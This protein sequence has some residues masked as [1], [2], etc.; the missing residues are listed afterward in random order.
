VTGRPGTLAAL[1]V[2]LRPVHWLKNVPV[3]A[4]LL[5]GGRLGDRGA[6]LAT[7]GAFLAFCGVAS[8]GYA[9]NDVADRAA[10]AAHPTRRLRP[11]AAGAVSP[12]AALALAAVLGLSSL[13]A[14]F[15]WLPPAAAFGLLAYAFLTLSYTAFAKRVTAL[16]APVLAAGFVLR[17]LVGAFAAGVEPSTWLVALTA[18]LALGLAVA[19]REAEARRERGEAPLG[20]RRATDAGLAAAAAGYLAYTLW[21]STVALHGTRGLAATTVPVALALWRFRVLLRRDATGR[22]PV[23]L[24]ARDGWLLLLGALWMASCVAVLLGGR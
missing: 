10:D 13:A 2:T 19:K 1:V 9:V 18:V 11:V 5:F 12:R 22:G 23:G 20:L 8:A 21:P 3:G 24:V 15:L 14:G 6:A 4:G 16:A 7:L 17:V